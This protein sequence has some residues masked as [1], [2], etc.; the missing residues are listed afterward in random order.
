MDD[1]DDE[2]NYFHDKRI[3]NDENLKKINVENK[4]INFFYKTNL[5]DY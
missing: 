3:L 1:D 5:L 4:K 2:V